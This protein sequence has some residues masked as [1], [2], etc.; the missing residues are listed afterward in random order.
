M[1]S[2]LFPTLYLG[3]IKANL[4]SFWASA[5]MPKVLKKSNQCGASIVEFAL[6]I[7]ILILFFL[8]LVELGRLL[9]QITWVG[10][11]A[12]QAVMIGGET[13]DV[14]G[15]AV[16][17]KRVEELS[18]LQDSQLTDQLNFID[19]PVYD[20]ENQ[21][22]SVRLG[23]EVNQLLN[24]P[25]DLGLNISVV[26]PTLTSSNPPPEGLDEPS[27]PSCVFYCPWQGVE[28]CCTPPCSA[29]LSTCSQFPAPL[30][31]DPGPPTPTP[32]PPGGSCFLAGTKILL[33]S[34]DYK[35]I[36][37]IKLG[38]EIKAFD[39]VAQDFKPG[40]V[41]HLFVHK[42]PAYYILNKNLNV[43]PEHRFFSEGKWIPLGELRIGDKLLNSQGQVVLIKSLEMIEQESTV[44]NFEVE[45]YHTYIAGDVVV[46]NA[47]VPT[48]LAPCNRP[49]L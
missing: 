3:K 36:E 16:M 15:A 11:T 40:K 12:Y 29:P 33:A 26:G 44:Y 28:P 17:A 38:D 47:K 31:G 6:F 27:N 18:E 32:R 41:V 37:E 49:E 10:Q 45:K 7:P 25:I 46:H 30:P 24:A 34:G 2:Q 39:E 21:T 4:Q 14:I 35:N 13:S 48:C 19:P 9:S 20:E 22:V 1:F 5:G 43:T 8:G 23:G 42:S